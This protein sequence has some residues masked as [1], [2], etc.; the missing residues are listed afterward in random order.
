MTTF[1]PR[2]QNPFTSRSATLSRC[3]TGQRGESRIH[4]WFPLATVGL[5]RAGSSLTAVSAARGAS[6]A[7]AVA[8]G[9]ESRSPPPAYPGNLECDSSRRQRPRHGHGAPRFGVPGAFSRHLVAHCTLGSATFTLQ[10]RARH[11]Y[12]HQST[13]PSSDSGATRTAAWRR[14]E[15]GCALP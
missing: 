3:S 2:R 12:G 10:I 5:R 15:A 7:L 14:E 11:K 6:P 1:P 8:D 13:A 9:G 4:P